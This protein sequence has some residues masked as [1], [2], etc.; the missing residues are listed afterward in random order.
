MGPV[1]NVDTGM[2]AFQRDGIA[3]QG[4]GSRPIRRNQFRYGGGMSG[5]GGMGGM[6]NMGGMASMTER[7]TPSPMTGS[8]S[9]SN[10]PLRINKLME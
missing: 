5:M 4:F 9:S 2:E 3:P 7:Y 10:M 1:I 6:N 8:S